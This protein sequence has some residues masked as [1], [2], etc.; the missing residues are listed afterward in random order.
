MTNQKLP[1]KDNGNFHIHIEYGFNITSQENISQTSSHSNV[2]KSPRLS[3]KTKSDCLRA[4]LFDGLSFRQIEKQIMGIESKARGGGFKAQTLMKHYNIPAS[5][6][7]IFK[8]LTYNEAC[9]RQTSPS[10]R[11]VLDYIKQNS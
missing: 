3:D 5:Q 7:G 10:L 1:L 8:N 2:S 9:I 6:K 4:Y 11:E